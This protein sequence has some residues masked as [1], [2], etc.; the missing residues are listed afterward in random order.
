M[1]YF[2]SVYLSFIS[3]AVFYPF[4]Y[5]YL[6]NYPAFFLSLSLLLLIIKITFVPFSHI[7]IYGY[8]KMLCFH[9]CIC[10]HVPGVMQ[11]YKFTTKYP[12]LSLGKVQRRQFREVHG[13]AFSQVMRNM[14]HCRLYKENFMC[15]CSTASNSLQPHGL[16]P[17]RLLLSMEFPSKNT[18]VGCHF[19]FQRIFLTQGSNP[20]LLYSALAGRFITFETLGNPT[21]DEL[22]VNTVFRHIKGF[23]T[24]RDMVYVVPENK[25]SPHC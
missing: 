24:R 1:L 17:S 3:L 10:F 16:Q 7:E 9:V 8:F 6:S 5:L 12:S 23:H 21:K 19:L 13:T 25:E 4:F 22:K 15:V 2:A 11:K 14:K 20:H 18:G